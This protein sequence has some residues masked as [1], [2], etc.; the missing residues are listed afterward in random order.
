MSVV[1]LWTHART[2][3]DLVRM[4]IMFNVLVQF[5]TWKKSPSSVA[6]RYAHNDYIIIATAVL[7]V[8]L[9]SLNEGVMRGVK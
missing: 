3:E 8:V 7:Q 9:Q 5:W 6:C 2:C 1:L 4:E